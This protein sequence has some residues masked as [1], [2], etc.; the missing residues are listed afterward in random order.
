MK[1][2]RIMQVA[3]RWLGLALGVQVALW[4]ASGFIMS[5]YDI[6]LVRG[7]TNAMKGFPPELE[8][9]SYANPGG[10]I[11][12]APGATSVRLKNFLNG[13]VYE[14]AGDAET[15]MF[16]AMSGAK[17]T[18]IPED[19]ARKIAH[20][21]FSGEGK[22]VTMELLR[23]APQEYRRAVPVWRAG[24][25]DRL[26]TRVYVSPQT[27][28]VAARRNDVWRLYDFFWMLHIMDYEEREDFNNPLVRIAAFTG[29]LFAL[30]GIY[31]VIVDL[32]RGRFTP[33]GRK[34]ST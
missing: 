28:E 32:M 25:D 10:V 22:I 11:A 34:R 13:P 18:P 4:M 20:R 12:Q 31:L 33:G 29:L 6:E 16:D 19:A 9:R 30:T 26:H 7:E 21:D 3:H 23:E 1:L 5:W 14:V 15:A 24:F 8:P 2:S 27:G 17:I